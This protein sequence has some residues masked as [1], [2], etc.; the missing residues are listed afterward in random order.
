MFNM[1]FKIA[2]RGK[3]SIQKKN[4]IRFRIDLQIKTTIVVKCELEDAKMQTWFYLIEDFAFFS[5]KKK[6]LFNF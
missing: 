2:L 3:N 1:K 6:F 4:E 5:S